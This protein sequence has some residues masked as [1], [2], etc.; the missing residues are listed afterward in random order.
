MESINPLVSIIIPTYRRPEY[1]CRAI[2]S[3]FAQKDVN[4]EVIVVDDNGLGTEK[5]KEVFNLIS[6]Y[7]DRSNFKYIPHAVNQNGAV[8]RNTGIR[9]AEGQYV[10]F[11]DDDDWFEE[12]KLSSQLALMEIEKTRA[13]LTGFQRIY[14]NN[15]EY[16]CPVLYDAPFQF[17]SVTIDACGG[18]GLVVEKELALQIGGFQESFQRHQDVEFNYRLSKETKISVVPDALVNVY[19]HSGNYNLKSNQR[20]IDA[21]L[22]F[23]D[24]FSSEIL[25][26]PKTIRSFIYDAQYSEISKAYLKDKKLLKAIKW[27]FKTSHPIATAIHLFKATIIFYKRKKSVQYENSH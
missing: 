10:A 12:N 27:V 2:D 17:L 11:L 20:I 7:L 14:A 15:K 13:C 25:R 9:F 24:V 6:S 22:H 21:K 8:A 18:S 1:I 16:G 4:I 26:Y 3:C 23:L 19:M 5:Q